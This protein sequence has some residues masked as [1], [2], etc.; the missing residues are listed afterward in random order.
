MKRGLLYNRWMGSI[1]ASNLSNKNVVISTVSD[2]TLQ[3]T[4]IHWNEF[5]KRVLEL[6]F[7]GSLVK[8]EGIWIDPA[9]NYLLYEYMICETLRAKITDVQPTG[10][11]RK[12]D[13]LTASKVKH[14][15]LDII[16]GIELLHSYGFLHPGLSTKKILI[17]KHG[18]CKLYD[19]C[20]SYDASKIVALKKPQTMSSLND[21][22]PEALFRNEYTQKSDVWSLAVVLW[23]VLS[24]GM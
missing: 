17:T 24:A 12:S 11:S 20:L 2:A 19:F 15:F 4:G 10:A 22:A 7:S 5:I 6:P 21:F 3:E 18:V 8:I 14:F 16:Q 1:A 9:H 13:T 23:E